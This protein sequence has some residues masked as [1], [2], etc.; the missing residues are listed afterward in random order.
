MSKLIRFGVSLSS[1]LLKQFDKL[2]DRK[3]YKNRSEAIRDL[4]REDL[5]SEEWKE[6]GRETV[7]VFSLVYD[8]HRNDL[9]QV[10]NNIQHDNLDIIRSSTHVH[11]DHKNCLEVI[12]LKGKSSEIKKLTDRLTSTKGIKHGKLIMTSTGSDLT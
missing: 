11:I 2:I 9:S 3:G 1:D 8:H 4:I 5:I 12:I 7:G 10:I 6:G